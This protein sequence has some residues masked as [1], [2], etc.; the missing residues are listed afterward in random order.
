[1]MLPAVGRG[2][3]FLA[4]DDEAFRTLLAERLRADG[5]EV[6]LATRPSSGRAA[7]GGEAARAVRSSLCAAPG[8]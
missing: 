7:A 2:A 1:M 3:V 6:E 4:E 5:H 8:E